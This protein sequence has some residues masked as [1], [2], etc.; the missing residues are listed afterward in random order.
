MSVSNLFGV[1]VRSA[2][3][4]AIA[5]MALAA[6][7]C[8][9][10]RAVERTSRDVG[11]PL[12]LS[13]PA[14]DG[15]TVDVGAEAGRVR[16]VD[17]W[18]TWCEPCREALPALDGLA[19]DLGPRGVSVYAVSIDADREQLVRFLAQHPVAVP[20]L[21]DKDAVR[22][23]GLDLTTLPATLV[24]D[25]RG[26]VRHVHQGWDRRRPELTRREVEALLSEPPPAP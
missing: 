6:A 17:I 10:P 15:R 24:V 16:V 20:V 21:W 8:A 2:L 3:S 25:R 11:H 22:A 26:I 7:A 19:R 5:L 14:L 4:G 1:G 13:A 18:A 23:G 12:T 9:A